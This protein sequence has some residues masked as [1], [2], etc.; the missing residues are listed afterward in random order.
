VP[1]KKTPTTT[2]AAAAKPAAKSATGKATGGRP[3]ALSVRQKVAARTMYETDPAMSK[4]KLAKHFGVSKGVIDRLSLDEGWNKAENVA[5]MS[6]AAQHLA[7]RAGN[8]LQVIE[9]EATEEKVAEVQRDLSAE[10]G[11]QL[12][13][14]VLSRHRKEWQIP[15]VLS[16]EAVRDRNFER[17]KLAKITAETLKI[18][19]EGER[20]AW[21]L[22]QGESGNT[23]VIERG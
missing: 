10:H 14:D 23:F 12:R 18:V 20:K 2:R 8:A 17:A 19:Q 15:R 1:T 7:D 13:A 16:Q 4:E 21:G 5:V 22:D 11:A 6:E 9:G 3:A